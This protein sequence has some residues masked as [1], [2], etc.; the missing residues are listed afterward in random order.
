MGHSPSSVREMKSENHTAPPSPPSPPSPASPGSQPAPKPAPDHATA[1]HEPNFTLEKTSRPKAV[2]ILLILIVGLGLLGALFM[3][4]WTPLKARESRLTEDAERVKSAAIKV[5]VVNA[6]RAAVSNDALLPGQIEAVRETTL[7][8][9]TTGYLKKWKVDIGDS[10]K[11]GQLLAEIDSPEVDMQLEQARA[12]LE[13]TRAT[14]QQSR[15]TLEQT[16]AALERSR[17]DLVNAQATAANAEVT[18]GRYEHLRGTNSVSDQDI[19]QRETDV[20]TTKAAVVADQAAVESAQANINAANATI[21]ASEANINAAESNVKRLEVL[22]SFQKILAPFDGTITARTA[23]EGALI[24]AGNAQPLFHLAC[25]DPVRVFID[26]PQAYAPTIKEGQSVQLVV[27]E[28]PASKFVGK[29][30]RTAGAIDIA[31]RTLR[32]EIQVPNKTGELLAGM[33]AQ[34]KLSIQSVTPPLV[35]PGS[36]MVVNADGTQVIVVK[37]GKVHFQK[38]KVETDLGSTYTVT[39]GLNEDDAVVAAP[40]ERMVEGVDVEIVTPK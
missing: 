19:S 17:A 21:K 28:Y 10:V 8:A 20:K 39:S 7:Y 34:V 15:A 1:E 13:Q 5:T 38:I 33:Y 24:T 36:T 37:D 40:N 11:T 2:W 32:T 4:G 25:T 18:M 23:E 22:Q 12:T 16:N 30:V 35:L 14:L 9:R 3:L 27:R 26:V 6:K 31:S 29:V